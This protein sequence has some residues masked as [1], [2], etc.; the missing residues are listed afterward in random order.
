MFRL[1]NTTYAPWHILESDDKL[2]ARVKALK[3][4]NDT[5]EARLN[6]S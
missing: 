3:V 5:L 4:I 2:Y 1:T 6:Q